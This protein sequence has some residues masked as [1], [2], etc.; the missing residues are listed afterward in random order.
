MQKIVMTGLLVDNKKHL[1]QLED[2]F[3]KMGFRKPKLIGQFETLPGEG[4]SGGRNDVVVAVN[5]KDISR[6]AVSAFHLNGGFHW[7]EDYISNHRSI[8]PAS[9]YKFF[10]ELKGE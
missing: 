1:K 10:D 3:K 9:A 4:S 6:L 7:V 2:G 8:I 5:D